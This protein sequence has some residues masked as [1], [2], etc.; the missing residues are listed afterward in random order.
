MIVGSRH[1]VHFMQRDFSVE[2][3]FLCVSYRS[4][5]MLYAFLLPVQSL[6]GCSVFYVP[7][8]YSMLSTLPESKQASSSMQL[9]IILL[10]NSFIALLWKKELQGSYMTITTGFRC[11]SNVLSFPFQYTENLFNLL[12]FL[13]DFM[14][15]IALFFLEIMGGLAQFCLDFALW[16]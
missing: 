3:F 9:Q 11:Q 4:C 16:L 2:L 10:C 13:L 5:S 7:T 1:G 12:A 14:G 8:E 15:H 6:L